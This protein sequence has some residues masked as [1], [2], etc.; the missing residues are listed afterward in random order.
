[1]DTERDETRSGRSR[2]IACAISLAGR[3]KLVTYVLARVGSNQAL[4]GPL[5]HFGGSDPESEGNRHRVS[6]L[7]VVET[8]AIS[9]GEQPI[10]NIPAGIHTQ[11]RPSIAFSFVA[12][13]RRAGG[14]VCQAAVT[15]LS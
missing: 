7:L 1:M 5:C 14:M 3:R 12:P 9:P 15:F 6:R 13:A 2:S 4:I 10:W 8:F 11:V